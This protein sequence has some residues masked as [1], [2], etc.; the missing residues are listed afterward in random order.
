MEVTYR[1]QLQVLKTKY[2]NMEEIQRQLQIE[3]NKSRDAECSSSI[4][5]KATR[6]KVNS[7]METIDN[8]A[9]ER[10]DERARYE[11]EIGLSRASAN[12]LEKRLTQERLELKEK[13]CEQKEQFIALLASLEEAQIVQSADL[14]M[15]GIEWYDTARNFSHI[16]ERLRVIISSLRGIDISIYYCRIRCIVASLTKH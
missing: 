2:E 16:W 15:Q 9:H 6:V 7:L 8:L 13:A 4:A 12:D 1:E 3:L 14:Q 5:L 11:K 10:S